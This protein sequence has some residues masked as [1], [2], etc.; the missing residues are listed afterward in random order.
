MIKYVSTLCSLAL[1]LVLAGCASP[2]EVQNM[3]VSSENLRVASNSPLHQNLSVNA[4]TGGSE[5]NP[6]WA[7]K[8]SSEDLKSALTSSLEAAELLSN[9]EAPRYI[10]DAKM[11]ALDQPLLG[12]DLTVTSKIG[13]TITDSKSNAVVYDEVITAPYTAE[14][15]DSLVAIRRLRLANEGAIRNNITQLITELRDLKV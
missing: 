14:F 10:L 2:A 8:V 3:V 6:L 4:V 9:K 7:S 5:T 12:L 15:G 1:L 11:L 13:Y